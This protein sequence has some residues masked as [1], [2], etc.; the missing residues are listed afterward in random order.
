MRSQGR[1]RD[2][3]PPQEDLPEPAAGHPAA[4]CHRWWHQLHN[5]DHFSFASLSP[6]PFVNVQALERRN[7]NIKRFDEIPMA[8]AE[9]VFPDKKIFLKPLLIIQLLI[10]I[11]GGIVA[12]FAALLSVSVLVTRFWR[13]LRFN[14]AAHAQAILEEC[15]ALMMFC[16]KAVQ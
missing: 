1:C 6:Q 10:A 16:I 4:D 2:D 12:T 14:P 15:C 3:G 13:D 5:C 9:M 11:I 7:I 8:D